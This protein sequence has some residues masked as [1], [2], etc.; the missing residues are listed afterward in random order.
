MVDANTF[1]A[2]GWIEDVCVNAKDGGFQAFGW[3]T[4]PT[5]GV[6]F[7]PTD[8]SRANVTYP[9]RDFDWVELQPRSEMAEPVIA[10]HAH[11]LCI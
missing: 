10:H 5:D 11:I 1:F 8:G 2:T 3:L 9:F 6:S 7:F 4:G